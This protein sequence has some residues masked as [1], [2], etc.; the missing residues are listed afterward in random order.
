VSLNKLVEK[1]ATVA[2][3][4]LDAESHYRRLV[5]PAADNYIHRITTAIMWAYCGY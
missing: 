4:Q 2:L 3:A 5:S 1:W